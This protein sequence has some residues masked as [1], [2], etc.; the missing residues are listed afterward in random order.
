MMFAALYNLQKTH[1]VRFAKSQEAWP[2]NEKKHRDGPG[3]WGG[4]LFGI[5]TK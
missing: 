3:P 1:D 2:E 5:T 4:W